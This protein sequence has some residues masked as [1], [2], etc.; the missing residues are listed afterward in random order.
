M[1]KLLGNDSHRNA[2]HGKDRAIGVAE[3]VEGDFWLDLRS[4]ASFP[5]WPQ[6]VRPSPHAT[7]AADENRIATKLA[8]GQVSEQPLPFVRQDDVAR[9]PCLAFSHRD[10]ARVGVEIGSVHTCQL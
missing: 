2:A 10:D 4:P 1:A 5:R 9:L 7:V 3:H 8:R 6:L